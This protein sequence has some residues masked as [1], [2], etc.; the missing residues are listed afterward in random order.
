MK[1]M[2]QR[3]VF[4]TSPL[5]RTVFLS[6]ALLLSNLGADGKNLAKATLATA[7]VLEHVDDF[8]FRKG[9]LGNG[10]NELVPILLVCNGM[11]SI[12]VFHH[13]FPATE[14]IVDGGSESA[15]SNPA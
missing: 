2:K 15:N 13:R 11:D 1:L 7:T 6:V 10:K 12:A 4:K 3:G 8:R 9:N 14:T 5:C